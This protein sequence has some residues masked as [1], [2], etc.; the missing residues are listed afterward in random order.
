MAERDDIEAVLA[1]IEVELP[2]HGKRTAEFVRTALGLE[3]QVASPRLGE[4]ITYCVREALVSVADGSGYRDELDNPAVVLEGLESALG[5]Y[6]IAINAPGADEAALREDVRTLVQ[7]RLRDLRDRK[8]LRRK[9]LLALIGTRWGVDPLG[10]VGDVGAEFQALLNEVQGDNGLHGDADLSVATGYLHR[11]T[12]LLTRIFVAPDNR[13]PDLQELAGILEPTAADIERLAF[14]AVNPHHL[15]YFYS[16]LAA[17][18]WLDELDDALTHPPAGG[19]PWPVLNAFDHLGITHG[20]Q[21]AAWLTGLIAGTK[22]N[23]M[24][25]FYVSHAA[26]RLGDRGTPVLLELLRRYPR[27]QRSCLV[28]IHHA[29]ER[30][31]SAPE[32]AD[33]A[34]I[35]LNES[36]PL[37]SWTRRENVVRPLIEGTTL[38]NWTDRVGRV[39]P[40]FRRVPIDDTERVRRLRWGDGSIASLDEFPDQADQ[41]ELLREALVGV[42]L[43]ATNEGASAADLLTAA[44]DLDE[45]LRN[46]LSTWILSITRDLPR[47]DALSNLCE[48]IGSHRPSVDDVVLLGRIEDLTPDELDG[49]TRAL[50]GTP[51]LEQVGD[52][53]AE[54]G[55]IPREW[56]TTRAW[57]AVLP[58][59]CLAGWQQALSLL[60]GRFDGRPASPPTEPEPVTA[61]FVGLAAMSKEEINALDPMSAAV[62]IRDWRPSG[63]SFSESARHLGRELQ[64]AVQEHPDVWSATPLEIVVALHEPTY[65]RHYFDGLAPVADKLAGTG[66][67]LVTAIEFARKHPWSAAVVGEDSFDFDP[68]WDQADASGVELIGRLAHA[69]IDLGESSDKAWTIAAEAM[70]DE[71]DTLESSSFDDPLTAAINQPRTQALSTLL[72]L[73]GAAKRNAYGELPTWALD[74]LTACLRL[75]GRAGEEHRAILAR[76]IGFLQ[77]IAGDWLEENRQLMFGADAP[78][79]LGQRTVDFALQ[80]GQK[81]RWLLENFPDQCFDSV[82]RGVENALRHILIGY[83]TEVEGLEVQGI[84]DRIVPMGPGIVSD[85][86]EGLARLL[87]GPGVEDRLLQR[88]IAFWQELIAADL[89]PDA[90]RG[91]GWWTEVQ[92]VNQELWLNLMVETATRAAGDIDWAPKTAERAATQPLSPTALGLLRILVGGTKEVWERPMVARSAIEAL[93]SVELKGDAAEQ[94]AARDTLRDRLLDLGFHNA[95]EDGDVS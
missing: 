4:T 13:L 82:S 16:K 24:Q 75:T 10:G 28:V 11:C 93:R 66:A 67:S 18:T 6:E 59:S 14:L 88:G 21:L 95:L 22:L 9:Q 63:A 49:F 37:D 44:C 68:D 27:H 87:R 39:A 69:N 79:S 45:D 80:W 46:R 26:D 57:S 19:E 74:E 34:D 38:A 43:T 15:S 55:N 61:G 72:E 58:D 50:P 40:K 12:T 62:V 70:N 41:F 86:G 17:P 20:E 85:A 92:A 8:G 73:M 47:R 23:E 29:N 64:A 71:G 5:D 65:V 51:S 94:V 48:S 77:Y 56:L 31:S 30:D 60:A 42:L 78:D 91:C 53:L 2:E 36:S 83:L 25:S 90:Y 52:A 33:M 81:N 76:V 32:I 54:G 1:R 84:L 35:L 89:A 3:G 7:N